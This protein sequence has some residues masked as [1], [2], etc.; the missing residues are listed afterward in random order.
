MKVEKGL[1]YFTLD[2]INNI[3]IEEKK[4]NNISNNKI[5][6]IYQNKKDIKKY[7]IFS[8]FESRI[9]YIVYLI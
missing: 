6:N 9:L 1:W 4:D 8:V 3:F 5:Y 2:D 7:N